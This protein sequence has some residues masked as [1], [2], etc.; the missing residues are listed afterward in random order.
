MLD[1]LENF[2]KSGVEEGRF[3]E[4]QAHQDLQIALWYAFA[5][6]NLDDYIH[7]YRAAEW[8]KDSEKNATGCATWYYRYSVALMY[9]GRLEEALEYAERGALE[10]P[11]YPWIWLHLGKLRAHFGDKSGALDAVKQGLKLEPGDYE[12]LTLKKEIKAGATL[13]Q[14]E[15]H[16]INPDADQTLQRGLDENADDK[17]CAITWIQQGQEEKVLALAAQYGMED[18]YA[19]KYLNTLRVGAETE[20]NELFDKSHGFYIAVIQ[21]FFR[22]YYYTR[23]SAFSFLVEQKPEYA[24]YFT[25]WEQITPVSFPNP[26]QNRI[27]ENYCSGVYLSPDQV[28][29]LL[30][31]M[32]QDPKVLEDLEGLWSNGQIAVLKK[33]L[34]AA[35][36][37]GVG[38]LE[39]TEVV[40]PNPISPNESTSY[41]NLYHCDRD[42]VYLYIDAVSGQ[43]ADAIGKN[44]G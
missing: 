2:I 12:F 37:S 25:S 11:D 31:D 8:M 30:K 13:E 3:S 1:W 10:E 7:Y 41:S 15:Y 28:I 35:A 26:M 40:E 6:L 22:D 36:K 20:S 16:W 21:G 32:E 27:I 39:A 34:S 17:Q 38:L 14:M 29:Q 23:G 24:R 18:F 44:E 4:K 43:L 33:A 9:C 42:G 19:E 5:C